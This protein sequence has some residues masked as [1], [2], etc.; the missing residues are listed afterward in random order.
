[1]E[2][3]VEKE[4]KEISEQ[5]PKVILVLLPWG[6]TVELSLGESFK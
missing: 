2:K 5:V 1:M 4:E 3:E 6:R